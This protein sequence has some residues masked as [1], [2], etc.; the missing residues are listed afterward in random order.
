[1]VTNGIL[2]VLLPGLVKVSI[3]LILNKL[4]S[5]KIQ[6]FKK[7]PLKD[8]KGGSKTALVTAIDKNQTLKIAVLS[9]FATAG[10]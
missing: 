1:M 3:Y 5:E 4:F 8:L 2:K 10:I 7:D 9:I 6:N